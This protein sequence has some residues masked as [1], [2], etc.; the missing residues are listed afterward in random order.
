MAGPLPGAGNT[1]VGNSWC[2]RADRADSYNKIFINALGA[3]GAQC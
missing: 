2:A 1:K 3:V